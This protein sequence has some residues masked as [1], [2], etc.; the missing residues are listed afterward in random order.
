M[1]IKLKNIKKAAKKLEKVIKK[2]PL[3]YSESFS[4]ITGNEIYLKPENFQKTGSFKIRGAYNKI[5]SLSEADKKKGIIAASAGNHAQGVAFAA[6][7]FGVEALIVMPKNAPISKITATEEYGARV[8]L[9]GD[10]YDEAYERALALQKESGAFFVHPFNDLE[11]IA[12]QATIFLEIYQELPD[13]EIILV[14]VGGGGLI[15]GIAAAASQIS[16]EVKIIGV[17]FESA[18]VM[19]HSLERDRLCTQS[20]VKS[21]ADGIAVK[22]PGDITFN[23]CCKYVEQILTVSEN[24]I[25]AAILKLLEE[26]KMIVEGAGAT[27]LAALIHNKLQVKNKKIVSL[28]SGGNIDI[29]LVSRIINRGLGKTDRRI[30]VK[31][32]IEDR[33]GQLYKL[34][35]IVADVDANVISISHDH[36]YSDIQI[37]ETLVSLNLEIRNRKHA[38]RVYQ[39]LRSEGYQ[40][41][42]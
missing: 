27:T 40:I 29:N 15:S 31:T 20:V 10:N 19:K 34:L 23:L 37:G 1:D 38:E 22:Q 35:E 16:P 12:G 28:L 9:A 26:E 13:V 39:A 36:Y 8:V 21:I 33:P 3:V 30:D 5:A 24:E 41:I 17:E 18:P 32:V 2:T 42:K 4:Q 11:L 6:C 7:K 14:P 25:A